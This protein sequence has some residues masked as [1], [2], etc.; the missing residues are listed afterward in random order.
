MKEARGPVGFSTEIWITAPLPRIWQLATKGA[1][2]VVTGEP[3]LL[4]AKLIHH[5]GLT[6]VI[7]VGGGYA[8]EN[9][10]SYLEKHGVAVQTVEGPRDPRLASITSP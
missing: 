5:A 2:L 8:G 6:R 1:W 10:L 4:C 3:C 7:V 9:G